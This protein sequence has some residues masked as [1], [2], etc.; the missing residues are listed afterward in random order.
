MA[1]TSV[2]LTVVLW[3]HRER[4]PQRTDEKG[5]SCRGGESLS[6]Q[7]M[8][9]REEAGRKLETTSKS[10]SAHA[11]TQGRC[12]PYSFTHFLV[13]LISE[14]PGPESVETPG[15]AVGTCPAGGSWEL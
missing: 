1:C 10:E 8:G 3:K 12:L 7:I 6:D 2:P 5:L 13:D 11:Q 4:S 9:R 15:H 14:H